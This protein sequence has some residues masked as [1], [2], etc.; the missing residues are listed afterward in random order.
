MEL[1]DYQTKTLNAFSR[2]LETLGQARRESIEDREYYESRGRAIPEATRNYPRVAWNH[3]EEAGEVADPT[4]P[5]V[6]RTDDAARPIPHVCFKFPLVGARR[7]WL[8]PRWIG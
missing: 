3:L 6:D 1:K 7:Y 4:R 2:W 8:P 5:Y